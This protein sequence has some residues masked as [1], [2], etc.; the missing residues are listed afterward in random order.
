MIKSEICIAG[1]LAFSVLPA[2]QAENWPEWRGASGTGAA[3]GESYPTHFSNS[4]GVLWKQTLPG[5]GSS[6][7]VVWADRIFLTADVDGIS[8]VVCYH[9]SG[10]K[11]WERALGSGA[12]GKHRASSGSNPSPVTDGE[13]VYVYFHSGALAAFDLKGKEVWAQNLQ[14][15][16]GPAELNFDVGTSPV[17]IRDGVMIAV[18]H[19]GESYLA[20]FDRSDGRE[21]WKS[22][23]E[24]DASGES[25]DAYTTPFVVRDGETESLLT[26]G[27]DHLAAFDAETGRS[28]WSCGGFN[29]EGKQN[30]RTIASAVVAE[31]IALVPYGRGD[32]LAGVAVDGTGDVTA[33]SKRWVREDVGADVPTPVVFDGR[34]YL[35]RDRGAL[36]CL[37]IQ[38]GK[39]HW[40]ARLPKHRERY[41]ASPLLAGDRIYCARLDGVVMVGRVSGVGF[42]LSAENDLT[43][44]IVASPIAVNG[45]L[46]IRGDKT[47]YCIGPK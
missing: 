41:F 21:R 1:I 17:L 15:T 47:L 40:T 37:D 46:L 10:K 23:R 5:R 4:D 31:G 2:A 39:D 24:F 27:A 19:K 3:E 34:A 9:E 18:M 8:T 42:E 16:Y 13:R 35:L 20:A 28:L 22:S 26:W 7:P 32:F 6:T 30:W 14:E 36:H 38:T 25:N 29:P 45:R 33:S 11:L 12:G 43:E 44:P